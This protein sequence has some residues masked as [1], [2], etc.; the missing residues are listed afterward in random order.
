MIYLESTM[1]F[2]NSIVLILIELSDE[3]FVSC[4]SILN[5]GWM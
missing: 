3:S 4:D 1:E 2:I 5:K